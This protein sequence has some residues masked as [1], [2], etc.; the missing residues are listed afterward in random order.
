MHDFEPCCFQKLKVLIKRIE[1][2]VVYINYGDNTAYYASKYFIYC[3]V[4]ICTVPRE[5]GWL[6]L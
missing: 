3:S 5:H 1:A 6:Q 2:V 4:H